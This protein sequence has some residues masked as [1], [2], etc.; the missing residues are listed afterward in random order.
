MFSLMESLLT[1]YC[2]LK[3]VSIFTPSYLTLLEGYSL[4]PCNFIFTSPSNFFCLDLKITI[5]DFV[6]QVKFYLHLNETL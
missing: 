6:Q 3:F 2:Q 4:L 1:L 5:S